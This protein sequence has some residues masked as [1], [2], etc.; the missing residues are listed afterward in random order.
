VTSVVDV[1]RQPSAAEWQMLRA[2]ASDEVSA[3]AAASL[4]GGGQC[5]FRGYD[6]RVTMTSARSVSLQVRMAH[7]ALV[8]QGVR[9]GVAS[10]AQVPAA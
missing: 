9:S 10:D 1:D 6:L 2:I 7:Q 8:A 3:A 5:R 4:T